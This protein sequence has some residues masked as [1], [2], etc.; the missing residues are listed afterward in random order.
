M[1]SGPARTRSTP[2]RSTPSR[3]ATASTVR[4]GRY[5]PYVE[6]GEERASVPED[7]APDE[8]TVERAEELLG[9]RVDRPGARRRIPR[10]G[11]RCWS[12]PAA[13]GPTCSWATPRTCDGKPRT[14]S[15][16]SGMDPAT[17][18]LEQAL[19]LLTLPRVVGADPADGEEI[20]AING[21]YGPVPQEGCRL[22]V[23]GQRG[24]ALH[25]HPGRGAGPVRPAQGPAGPAVGRAAAGAGRRPGQRAAHACC[26][27]GRFGPVRDRRR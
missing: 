14:A 7:L 12:G 21:R 5:G 19:R 27:E 10:P 6:R 23:A 4:V 20:V 11:C 17:L 1:V 2:G 18:T 25:R 13:S 16:L 3:S 26:K 15:L 9:G 8:L 22:A 24:P